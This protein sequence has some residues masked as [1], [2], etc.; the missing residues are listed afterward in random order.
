MLLH[1]F[2]KCVSIAFV[3]SSYIAPLLSCFSNDYRMLL[4]FFS[5]ARPLPFSTLCQD[6]SVLARCFPIALSMLS[7]T[8]QPLH[9]SSMMCPLF[10]KCFSIVFP[11][12]F[13]CFVVATQ[14]LFECFLKCSSLLVEFFSI[15]CPWLSD[16]FPVLSACFVNVF[17]LLSR[18]VSIAF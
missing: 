8:S 6:F 10:L 7:K 15:A 17:R 4:H 13:H 2:S 12:L 18:C 1:C 14:I 9:G 5:C 3:C 11:A 16:A